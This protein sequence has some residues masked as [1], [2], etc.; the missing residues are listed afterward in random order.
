M[1]MIISSY[2]L[3][4]GEISAPSIRGALTCTI[5]NGFPI[6]TLFGNVMGPNMSMMYFGIISLILTLCFMGIFPFFPQTPYYYVQ[7]NDTKRTEKS[8]QWYYQK[9]DVRSEIEAIE[10]FVKEKRAMN[11][12]ERLKQLK[13]PKNRRAFLMLTMLNIFTQFC[14]VSTIVF[15]M[16]IIVTKGRVT[17]IKPS[18]L[19]IIINT[20]GIIIGW[21]GTFVIDHSGRRMVAAISSFG[22]M[23]GMA[24][25]GLHF[26]LLDYGYDPSGLEWL[27]VLALLMI[28]LLNFGVTQMPTTLMSE[29]FSSDLKS[30]GGF[31]GSIMSATF[32]F[33]ASKTYQP[34]IDLISAKYVYWIYA[35]IFL[36]SLVYSL[37]VLPETKGKTLEEIQEMMATKYTTQK[38]QQVG[39]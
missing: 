5:I 15:Y 8:I 1:G 24:L 28:M 14:G 39:S 30:V 2:P 35:V 25:L 22:V 9:S 32:A 19:V 36:I 10:Y 4:I 13:E 26:F 3:Y 33:I 17:M 29:I 31:V 12:R 23:V 7:R 27:M 20:I 6:G 21:I 18:T 37:T 38:S 34:L 16:E 11:M